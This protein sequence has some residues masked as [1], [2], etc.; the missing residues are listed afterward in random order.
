MKLKENVI[1]KYNNDLTSTIINVGTREF[2]IVDENQIYYKLLLNPN[3]IRRNSEF[4]I[5][6]SKNNLIVKDFHLDNVNIK[7]QKYFENQ[8]ISKV[9]SGNWNRN[10]T[11]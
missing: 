5:F 2:K 11:K 4:F 6:L 8:L 10:N 9:E 7:T 3:R 1:I